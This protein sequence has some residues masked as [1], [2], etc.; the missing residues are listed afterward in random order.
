MGLMFVISNLGFQIENFKTSMDL[1]G[2]NKTKK[3]QM[4]FYGRESSKL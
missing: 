1:Y 3:N 4:T 2:Q